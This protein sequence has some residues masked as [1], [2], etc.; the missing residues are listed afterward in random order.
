MLE[1]SFYQ[2][3]MLEATYKHLKLSSFAVV[4][5]AIVLSFLLYGH[6]ES[7]VLFSWLG[8]MLFI[9]SLRFLSAS[10]F[11]SHRCMYS[12]QFWE[13]ILFAGLIAASLLWASSSWLLFV[14]GSVLHQTML[15]IVIAGMSAGAIA[16]LS[17]NLKAIQIFLISM[18]LPL[19]I[20]LLMQGSSQYYGIAFLIVLFLVLLLVTA[21]KYHENYLNIF[22][23]QQMYENEKLKLEVSEERFK[24]V[25]QEAPVG[26]IIYDLDLVIR[27]VNQ[28][29][30]DIV[31]APMDKLF[32]LDMNT[33]PD[34]RIL[35]TLK[36]PLDYSDGFYEGE[37]HTKYIGKDIWI[38]MNT[39]PLFGSSKEPIG[40]IG[41]ISDITQRIKIQQDIEHQANYD[42]LTNIPN[43]MNIM[44]R[45]QQ[46]IRRYNR[47]H[48]IFG[49]LFLDLDHFK[50]I[51][52]SLGH[53][54][55]D[56]L[57]IETARRLQNTLREEDVVARIGGDEFVVLLPDLGIHQEE[58]AKKAEVIAQKIH[59]ILKK[60]FVIEEHN[61][62]ISTS[63]GIVLMNNEKEGVDELLKHADMAMYQ[64]KK[65]GRSLSR[66]YQESMDAWIKRHLQIENALRDAITHKELEVYYQ[67]I[68]EFSSSKIIGAEALLRWSHPILGNIS[69]EEFIPVAEDSGMIIDIG[70]WVLKE[71]SEQFV[72]WQKQF[73]HLSSLQKIAVNVSSKQFNHDAFLDV[74]T[75]NI[76]SSAIQPKYLELELTESIIIDNTQEVRLKMKNIRDL[77]VGLSIDDFGT[78]YS[79][80]SYLKQLPFTTLKIDQSF[81]RD[82]QD[83]VDDKELISTIITIA[84]NFDLKVVAEGVETYEQFAFLSEKSCHYCQG[85]YC[86]KPL[87]A[88]D[89][90]KLLS[91]SEGI[92]KK[93]S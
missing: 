23:S 54:I 69:P 86:A 7:T 89:F 34:Q 68:V 76:N 83:D 21:K 88:N 24:A 12:D 61:L 5:N 25:F 62:L 26:I 42:T 2:D 71:A 16:S 28:V 33:L 81:V 92:W 40:A 8:L 58:A 27:D 73:P 19:F 82:I 49:M 93:S 56:A 4:V 38:S 41:I 39:T 75:Q 77:D 3:K 31:D 85:Y 74:L 55:G 44:E 36:A 51:N 32:E 22:K 70:A 29:F 60:T 50:N 72:S 37:Y 18:L 14:Q 63:I 10:Y 6:I 45:I 91:Q 48:I 46:E 66:F 43:R 80:L 57:L 1:D 90:T 17:A 79:S 64:A 78:G 59:H 20:R 47:H 9:S 15:I 30:S 53:Y 13:K 35:P 11:I 65:D 52:D 87:N 84:E 67:P